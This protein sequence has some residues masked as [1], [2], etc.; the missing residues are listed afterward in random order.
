MQWFV[1]PFPDAV[2]LADDLNQ[3]LSPTDFNNQ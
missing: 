2:S 1:T 3:P